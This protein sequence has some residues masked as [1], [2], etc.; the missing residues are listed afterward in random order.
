LAVLSAML[1]GVSL[2]YG[3]LW[4]RDIY[5]LMGERPPAR[6]TYLGILPL[7]ALLLTVAV[8][9]GRA[10]RATVRLVARL[11]ARWI[12]GALAGV[13]GLAGVALLLVGL[14]HG[15]VYDGLLSM[16]RS[17][18]DSTN[19][20]LLTGVAPPVSASRSGSP[21]SL[22]SWESLGMQGRSF[23]SSGPTPEQ[24][25]R[26]N[27]TPAKQPIRVYVGLDSQVTLADEAALAVRELHRTGA[28]SRKV[29]CVVTTTGTGWVDPYAADALE[30]LYNGDTAIVGMQY[31]HLPSWISFLTE[32][33]KVEDAARELFDHVYADWS[34][35]PAGQ[36]PKL[37]VFGESLGSLGS[38]ATF[39]GIDD[40]RN[41]TDGVLWVG[42]TNAN[43]L[44]DRFVTN[45]DPGSPEILPVYRQGG[46]VRFASD[47]SD[48]QRPAGPWPTPR[49]VYLQNPTDPIAWWSPELLL[50]RP[51]WLKERRGYDVLPA[52][53]W[54]PFVTFCQV[55]ADLALAEGAPRDHGHSY[56]RATVAAWAAVA[57][58]E[59]WSPARSAQL[60]ELLHPG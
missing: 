47:P 25:Q 21:H 15:V 27:R 37:L 23:V 54:Y 14:M 11:V 9:A 17:A 49:V 55:T 24:L 33:S 28:F 16:A 60:T 53:R 19:S 12:P 7:S 48:L 41:R 1:L 26:F 32:R 42:P 50:R 10:L 39:S 51:D 34:A 43:S 13:T 59:G 18:S 5:R 29:L 46:T 44:R 6:H 38:E 30:Y 57:A 35:L 2:Y 58:P 3:S 45:R 52:M 36:R 20:G 4:Q 40:I 8:T 56:Q 31:S 22:V